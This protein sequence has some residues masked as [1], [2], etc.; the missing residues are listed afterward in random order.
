MLKLEE[1]LTLLLTLVI[2]NFFE[3][4]FR[5]FKTAIKYRPCLSHC[6]LY[7]SMLYYNIYYNKITVNKPWFGTKA[8]KT[9]NEFKILLTAKNV[10]I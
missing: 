7:Y 6:I 5:L 2:I 8:N 9:N 1:T 4:P 3:T 10:F